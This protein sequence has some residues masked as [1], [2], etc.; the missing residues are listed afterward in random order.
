M[1]AAASLM[2]I[3]AATGPTFAA[4]A[5]DLAPPAEA[6]TS[7]LAQ[8]QQK[9]QSGQHYIDPVNSGKRSCR[10]GLKHAID[11]VS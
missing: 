10:A 2:A 3:L 8:F 7:A 6:P 11:A 5:D 4:L 9:A 1:T